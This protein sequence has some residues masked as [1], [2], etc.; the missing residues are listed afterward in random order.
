MS[1]S[2][3]YCDS[4]FK[5]SRSNDYC[6]CRFCYFGCKRRREYICWRSETPFAS[7]LIDVCVKCK[8]SE[9]KIFYDMDPFALEQRKRYLLNRQDYWG[10]MFIHAV[11]KRIVR[12]RACT[13]KYFLWEMYESNSLTL[14]MTFTKRSDFYKYNIYIRFKPIH[15]I[16]RIHYWSTNTNSEQI[17]TA[18]SLPRAIAR[19]IQVHKRRDHTADV[20]CDCTRTPITRYKTVCQ[21]WPEYKHTVP[22]LCDLSRHIAQSYYFPKIYKLE[23]SRLPRNVLRQIAMY[24]GISEAP[25]TFD[26]VS[27][28]SVVV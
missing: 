6:D 16:Y 7:M 18:F 28:L 21:S 8:P 12:Q 11:E 1:I 17:A 14:V 13:G 2:N 19:A 22:T 4:L 27:E 26:E 5:I 10:I 23:A 15:N 20:F 9:K 24:N 25:F 3:E